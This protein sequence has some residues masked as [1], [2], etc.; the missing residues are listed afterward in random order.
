VGSFKPNPFG[1]Y[2]TIGNAWEWAQVP[3]VRYDKSSGYEGNLWGGYWGSVGLLGYGCHA[4]DFS[5][6]SEAEEI[7][8]D[9]APGLRLAQDL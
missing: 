6:E 4:G 1:L 8:R 5:D 3:A 2:D 7:N 9:F